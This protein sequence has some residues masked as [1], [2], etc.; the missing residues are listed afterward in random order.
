MLSRSWQKIDLPSRAHSGAPNASGF[1]SAFFTNRNPEPSAFTKPR[2]HALS[3]IIEKSELFS[4]RRPD[5]T[6]TIVARNIGYN[7]HFAV[8][9]VGDC[10][11]TLRT[12]A[13]LRVAFGVK[14][15]ACAVRRNLWPA[16]LR[17]F[18]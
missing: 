1:S 6:E 8:G 5:R 2:C 12:R 7:R 4:I 17:N 13:I 18:L 11:V 14:C 16:A 9:D 15:D 3:D 10:N